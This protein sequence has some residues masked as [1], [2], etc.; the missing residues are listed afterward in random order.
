MHHECLGLEQSYLMPF[1]LMWANF[2]AIVDYPCLHPTQYIISR[3]LLF[4]EA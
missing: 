3:Q 1:C 2:A 4:L